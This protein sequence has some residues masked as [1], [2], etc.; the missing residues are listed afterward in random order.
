MMPPSGRLAVVLFPH[1]ITTEGERPRALRRRVETMYAI[2]WSAL[3]RVRGSIFA[4]SP[5][6]L[7]AG[8]YAVMVICSTVEWPW[9]WNEPES[10]RDQ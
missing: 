3:W 10:R 1:N 9:P 4:G 8:S 2:E 5:M 7:N 6:M